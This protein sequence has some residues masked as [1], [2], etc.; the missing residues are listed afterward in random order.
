GPDRLACSL[1][2]RRVP[3]LLCGR[4]RLLRELTTR[5]R[6]ARFVLQRTARGARARSRW[7]PGL[8]AV[9]PRREI[10]LGRLAC[11]A[12]SALGRRQ[13]HTRAARLRQPDGDRLFRR[14]CAVLA[15]AN[16]VDLLAHELARRR[17]GR[18]PVTQLAPG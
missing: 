6:A 17:R 9:L 13:R 3:A 7:G 12:R 14:A 10:A 2:T 1:R 15:P 8:A 11:S 4:P 5:R 18:A 16:V